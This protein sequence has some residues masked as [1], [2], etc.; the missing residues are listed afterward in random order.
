MRMAGTLRRS[1][2]DVP[3]ASACLDDIADC[4]AIGVPA[5]RQLT[6]LNRNIVNHTQIVNSP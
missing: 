6:G 4:P 3:P 2:S 5:A 1:L